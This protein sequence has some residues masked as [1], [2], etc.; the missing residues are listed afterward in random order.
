M[1]TQEQIERRKTYQ[2]AYQKKYYATAKRKAQ[3]K[4][5]CASAGGKAVRNAAQKTYGKSAKGRAVHN[6]W[7]NKFPQKVRAKK[8]VGHAIEAGKLLREPCVICGNPRSH[9]HHPD[10]ERPM[11]VIW[12][13]ALHHRQMHT[14]LVNLLENLLPLLGAMK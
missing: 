12:L 11:W 9:G 13:C 3:V 1:K 6:R 2:R 8:A 5:Y 4:R 10:Y 7:T 14:L